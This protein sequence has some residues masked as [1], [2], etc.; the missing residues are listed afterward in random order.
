MCPLN[1]PEHA[2]GKENKASTLDTAQPQTYTHS[3]AQGGKVRAKMS[4][5]VMISRKFIG[6][7]LLCIFF[8]LI[9]DLF[10]LSNARHFDDDNDSVR[11]WKVKTYELMYPEAANANGGNNGN[12][13]N[14]VRM[15][16]LQEHVKAL[17]KNLADQKEEFDLMKAEYNILKTNDLMSRKSFLE[18]SNHFYSSNIINL[19]N[20][21]LHEG[22]NMVKD[23]LIDKDRKQTRRIDELETSEF[24]YISSSSWT[25]GATSSFLFV[26]PSTFAFLLYIFYHQ[27]IFQQLLYNLQFLLIFISRFLSISCFVLML[28]SLYFSDDPF[29]GGRNYHGGHQNHKQHGQKN[30]MLKQQDGPFINLRNTNVKVI[31]SIKWWHEVTRGIQANLCLLFTV[32][33]VLLFIR[34][35]G[36]YNITMTTKASLKRVV[37]LSLMVSISFYTCLSWEDHLHYH[38]HQYRKGGN[39]NSSSGSSSGGS[40]GVEQ[41]KVEEEVQLWFIHMSSSYY[42]GVKWAFTYFI[43]GMI[44]L[45]LGYLE[46]T[47]ADILKS[48]NSA[49]KII[50][51][52]K[53]E[54]LELGRNSNNNNNHHHSIGRDS[55]SDRTVSSL[56]RVYSETDSIESEGSECYDSVYTMPTSDL[57]ISKDEIGM[58]RTGSGGGNGQEYHHY[59][60]EGL[61]PVRR[62]RSNQW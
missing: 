3:S 42:H 51:Q 43:F 20:I 17:Y 30:E 6:R 25:Q 13:D 55:S 52:K 9:C 2:A 22:I 28:F 18:F 56:L 36:L 31:D 49:R 60:Q 44:F 38:H 11:E 8:L 46:P 14:S 47:S 12:G 59:N 10:S 15:D 34:I 21:D 45:S 54:D 24:L 33:V 53:N 61:T 26:F 29:H 5:A 50:I 58:I 16:R 7:S 40:G 27:T 4:L 19:T 32:Y 35:F 37:Q 23:K 48:H 57:K 39:R 1:K 62:Q 41:D